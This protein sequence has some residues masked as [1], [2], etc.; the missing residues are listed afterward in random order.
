VLL[1]WFTAAVSVT[2]TYDATGH[3]TKIDYGNGSVITYP[4]DNEEDQITRSLPS[5]GT[6]LTI[7][8]G[9]QSNQPYGTAPFSVSGPGP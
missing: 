7:T 3:L 1:R 4:Y 5:T 6:A 2:Y 9:A 8:F